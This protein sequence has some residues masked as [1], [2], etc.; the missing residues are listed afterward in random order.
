ML[1]FIV[2]TT[3]AP[4]T[5][6]VRPECESPPHLSNSHHSE[7]GHHFIGSSVVYEC[8]S[9]YQTVDGHTAVLGCSMNSENKAM[10]LG[11]RI[12]CQPNTTEG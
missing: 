7:S 9:G 3:A 5:T 6:T 2:G 12:S 1:G 10:W 11:E 8:N 4:I